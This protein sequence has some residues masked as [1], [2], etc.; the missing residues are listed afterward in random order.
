MRR[1]MFLLYIVT[2]VCNVKSQYTGD[3]RI[4]GGSQENKGRLEIFFNYTWGTVCDDDFDNI[5]ANVACRQLGYCS[6]IMWRSQFVNDGNGTIWLDDVKCS[7]TESRLINCSYEDSHNCHHGE[8][9]GIDCDVVCPETGDLRL[10]DSMRRNEGRLEIYLSHEWGTVCENA[11]DDIDA[12]VACRQLGYRTGTAIRAS[13]IYDGSGPIWLN[14]LG[15]N[16]NL[17]LIGGRNANEGRLEI[18]LFDEWGTVCHD[19]FNNID[20]GVACKQ[21]GYCTGTVLPSK[22][23]DDGNGTIWL[24]NVDCVGSEEKLINCSYDSYLTNCGHQNDVGIRCFITCPVQGHLRIADSAQEHEGRLEIYMNGVWGTVCRDFFDDIDATVACQQLGY[25]SGKALSSYDVVDGTGVIWIDD[26]HCSG[27]ES[28]LMTCTYDSN[29]NDCGTYEDVGVS[30][31]STCPTTVNGGWSMWSPWSACFCGSHQF[32]T[33]NCTNPTP[34][35]GG[36]YCEG[37]PAEQRN[38]SSF[39][40]SSR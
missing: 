5:D 9:V 4:I 3:L 32:R 38:C 2:Q 30:C 27:I 35:Y 15:C 40:Y 24:D 33:R 17:R 11:F 13:I 37:Y 20:A 22:H 18:N 39:C 31:S 6:G 23:V 8:D 12:E 29:T 26:L 14:S 10:T 7:G 36:R 19:Y 28:K 34:M 25:C 16:G 21:L 1:L